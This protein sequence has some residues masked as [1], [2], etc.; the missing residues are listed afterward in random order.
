MR[1]FITGNQAIVRGALR[2]GCNYFAGYPITP[3]SS[4]LTEF[5]HAFE[6]GRG[7]AIQTEDEIA[8]IGQCIGAAMAGAKALTASSGPGLSL[9]SENIGLAQMGEV[10][11]VIVDCQRMGPATGGATATGEG[12][13]MFARYVSGGGYPLPV[14]AATDAATAYA[15]TYRAF[16]I[17]ERLRTPVIVLASKDIS[18]TRQTVDLEAVNLPERVDRTVATNHQ[19]FHS[20]DFKDLP[21]IPAFLPIGASRQV[22]FTGSIHDQDGLITT[23]RSRVART[24]SH[25]REKIERNAGALELVRWDKD[26]DARTL[27]VS[28][29]LADGAA[30][31]AVAQARARGIGVANLTLLSLWPVPEAALR[32]AAGP[33]IQR[34]IVPELNVGLYVNEI[35]R[36]LPHVQVQSILRF[37]GGLISPQTILDAVTGVPKASVAAEWSVPCRCS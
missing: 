36:V 15:L 27:I 35:R 22:R 21:D 32:T 13:V 8:A 5:V 30:R 12:D 17:A 4:I 7:V 18:M 2:A 26:A 9:Y 23:D 33:R 10:P 19:P 14:L 25:L 16:N 20:Y 6:D 29:G 3:A 28:Y 34:V 31:V 1:E 37:D 11:L 24:L